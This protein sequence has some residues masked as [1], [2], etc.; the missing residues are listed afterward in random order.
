MPHSPRFQI[1]LCKHSPPS[2][3]EMPGFAGRL[4][5]E[6]RSFP[7]KRRPCCVAASNASSCA[8]LFCFLAGRDGRVFMGSARRQIQVSARSRAEGRFVTDGAK[9]QTCSLRQN[10]G[11]FQSVPIFTWSERKENLQRK[12]SLAA[13]HSWH[14][15]I[16][17]K[18]VA[19]SDLQ[20]LPPPQLKLNTD[21]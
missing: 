16:C 10:C 13:C 3:P 20:S 15:A 14:R 2:D 4:G 12:P 1:T 5:T 7:H 17:H 11:S 6:P 8:S 18:P 21:S 19:A 9:S